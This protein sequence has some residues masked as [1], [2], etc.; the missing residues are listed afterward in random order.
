M[1]AT[2]E[3]LLLEQRRAINEAIRALRRRLAEGGLTEDEADDIREKL[4]DLEDQLAVINARIDAAGAHPIAGPDAATFARVRDL[5]DQV[6][7]ATAN[8]R[9]VSAILELVNAALQIR[10]G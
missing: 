4:S 6:E 8:N 2:A 7:H 1:S 3:D 10:N 9:E 5:A